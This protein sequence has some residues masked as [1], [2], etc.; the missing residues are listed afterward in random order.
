[1]RFNLIKIGGLKRKLIAYSFLNICL[2]ILLFNEGMV[3]KEGYGILVF[4]LCVLIVCSYLFIDFIRK[5]PRNNARLS[6]LLIG[7]GL[8]ISLIILSYS[9]LYLQT[10][11][12]YGSKAFTGKTLS[13]G[14][15]LYYSITTFTTTGYGDITSVGTISN[16]LAASEMLFGSIINTI[17]IAVLTSILLNRLKE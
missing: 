7:T 8:L 9:N 11:R 1:M 4:F 13:S 16:A 15:F 5:I 14:D 17:L 3:K 10:H 12:I 6:Y 2:V